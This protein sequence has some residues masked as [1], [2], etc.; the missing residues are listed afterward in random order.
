MAAVAVNEGHFRREGGRDVVFGTLGEERCDS[1]NC[2][3]P[4]KCRHV[5][6]DPSVMRRDATFFDNPVATNEVL[7]VLLATACTSKLFARF[8]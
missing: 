7:L 3:W 4:V 2:A 8:D 6:L 1:P 5:T